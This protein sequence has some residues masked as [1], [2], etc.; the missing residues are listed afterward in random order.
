MDKGAWWSTVHTAFSQ[1]TPA[2]DPAV[3]ARLEKVGAGRQADGLHSSRAHHRVVKLQQ[4]HVVVVAVLLVVW[5]QEQAAHFE[6]HLSR[7]A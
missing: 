2:C 5:V 6:G 3:Q 4:G 7:P 1:G